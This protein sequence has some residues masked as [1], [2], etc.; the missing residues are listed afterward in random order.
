MNTEYIEPIPLKNKLEQND[1]TNSDETNSDEEIENNVD[2]QEEFQEDDD[3][4]CDEIKELM[5][6]QRMK[7][8]QNNQGKSQIAEKQNNIASSMKD[9]MKGLSM[10]FDI[11]KGFGINK[12]ELNLA[13]EDDENDVNKAIKLNEDELKKIEVIVDEFIA[14]IDYIDHYIKGDLK[15]SRDICY[16]KGD[17]YKSRYNYSDDEQSANWEENYDIIVSNMNR[18]FKILKRLDE[19]FNL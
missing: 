4:E 15:Y 9:V 2:S 10:G 17:L 18:L 11:L 13:D 7:R 5:L 14:D 12:L 6:E 19:D 1:K 16:A 8:D 3:E